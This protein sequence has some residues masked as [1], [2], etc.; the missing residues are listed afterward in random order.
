MTKIRQLL[1]LSLLPI[2]GVAQSSDYIFTIGEVTHR[3]AHVALTPLHSGVRDIYAELVDANTRDT[4][5][6]MS[7]W[8]GWD[9]EYRISYGDQFGNLQPD[10]EYH[11]YINV[12]ADSLYTDFY[13]FKTLKD[14][15]HEGEYPQISFVTGSC[16]YVND[17]DTDRPG[18]GYG[19][20][21]EIYN[22][23]LQEEVDFNLWLGDNIY[24]RPSDLTDDWGLEYRYITSFSNP[25]KR[26]L[27]AARPNLAI[28]DDH[29]AGPNNTTSAYLDL[30][31]TNSIF[32]KFWPRNTYGHKLNIGY[33]YDNRWVSQYG[34]VVII[35]LDNRTYR[36]SEH[37]NEPQ[38][39]GKD[40]IDWFLNTIEMYKR[41]S[42]IIVAFGGQV[43]NSAKVYENY[44]QYPEEL[45]YLMEGIKRTG[46]S[47]LV[48]FTGDRHHSELSRVD[49][50]SVRVLDFTVSPLSSGVSTV[51]EGEQNDNRVG[52]AIIQRNYA[53][54]EIT[55]DPGE[56]T[57]Q[58]T[59]KDLNG[60]EISYHEFKSM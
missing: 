12:I 38:I 2:L 8:R 40:Q 53:V 49:L 32:K 19:G 21:Y 27:L 15:V 25:G 13:H 23:M 59:Y 58:V 7:L 57:L 44:A 34:D 14:W 17:P 30:S 42:F 51:A 39:L 1:F 24:L 36:T 10:N 26:A 56:R 29:D 35:G 9:R 33:S 18:A 55:G 60:D 31:S 41:S 52:E 3:S 43:L 5:K 6:V 16:A 28:W 37:S 22:A 54:V 45:S 46:Y 47:N 11:L 50:D 4:I 48:F 20:G